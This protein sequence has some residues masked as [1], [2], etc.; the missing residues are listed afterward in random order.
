MHSTSFKRKDTASKSPA[1]IPRRKSGNL[2]PIFSFEDNRPEI[3]FQRA[4]REF[5]DFHSAG[6]PAQPSQ[7]STERVVQR[8]MKDSAFSSLYKDIDTNETKEQITVLL[9]NYQSSWGYGYGYT[10]EYDGKKYRQLRLQILADLD[11][12]IHQHF[13]NNGAV[14]IN[15]AP[16]SKLMLQLLDEVQAEHEKQIGEITRYQDELPVDE[17]KLDPEEKKN[18]QSTWQSIIKG[19]GNIRITEKQID[20]GT[21]LER[22]HKGFRVKA[23]AS[24]ARLLQGKQGRNLVSTANAGGEDPAKHITIAPVSNKDH[25]IMEGGLWKKKKGTISAAGWDAEPSDQSGNSLKSAGPL[26]VGEFW[27]LDGDKDPMST[28]ELAARNFK[29]KGK[30]N[31]IILRDKKYFFNKGTGSRVGFIAEH[32]DSDNRV[33]TQDEKEGLS[34]TSIALGHELG[35]AIRNRRGANISSNPG[36]FEEVGI[37][38]EI[39]GHWTTDEEELV[40]ITQVENKLLKEKGL[41]PRIFHKDYEESIQENLNIRLEKF[42]K[43]GF[44]DKMAFPEILE[45]ISQKKFNQADK[46][47]TE[48]GF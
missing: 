30:P 35:H 45:M 9:K 29:S 43:S 18:I 5:A 2:H 36:F 13:R 17:R 32:K 38:E 12:V 40:N 41:K 48:K 26:A 37:P 33:M 11:N 14:R 23:L 7:T 4:V 34:P 19:T 22:D 47:L 8:L 42:Q 46:L 27:K 31:G 10:P 1:G 25:D 15:D 24:I 21:E 39:K 28:Y 16:E 6:Q 20:K 44:M 3:S